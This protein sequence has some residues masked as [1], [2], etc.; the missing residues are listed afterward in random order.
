VS[1]NDIDN[2]I[3]NDIDNDINNDIDTKRNG[4]GHNR[5]KALRAQVQEYKRSEGKRSEEGR[6]TGRTE[7]R[8]KGRIVA[9]KYGSSRSRG[10]NRAHSRG[11]SEGALSLLPDNTMEGLSYVVGTQLKHAGMDV[12]HT[13]AQVKSSER[14]LLHDGRRQGDYSEV[15][16]ELI[17]LRNIARQRERV[18]LLDERE[19]RGGGSISTRASDG[20][21]DEYRTYDDRAYD[22][23][24]RRRRERRRKRKN[25][26]KVK[27]VT[28][29]IGDM[30]D[31]GERINRGKVHLLMDMM[32]TLE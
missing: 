2:G 28:Q 29:C 3:D 5:D 6:T 22:S 11:Y 24:A 7:S 21:G 12:A 31:N 32:D 8:T 23:H 9:Q 18:A 4:D 14:A 1:D 17:R 25:R 27:W 15:R 16:T 10:S 20:E 30:N 26:R 13:H 19:E